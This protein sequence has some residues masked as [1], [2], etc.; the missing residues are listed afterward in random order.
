VYV[1]KYKPYE[2]R[3]EVI[4]Q[5]AFIGTRNRRK[6]SFIVSLD[7]VFDNYIFARYKCLSSDLRFTPLMI[8]FIEKS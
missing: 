1:N 6:A 5:F 7:I 4:I 8:V 3:E 2:R